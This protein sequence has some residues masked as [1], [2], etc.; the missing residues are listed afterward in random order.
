MKATKMLNCLIYVF[1]HSHFHFGLQ[2]KELH[3]NKE[4][5][6]FVCLISVPHLFRETPHSSKAVARFLLFGLTKKYLV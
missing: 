6:L 3:K 2:M 5:L 4:Q 1:P